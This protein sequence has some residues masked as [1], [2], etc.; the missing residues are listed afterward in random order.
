MSK[1]FIKRISFETEVENNHTRF[2]VSHIVKQCTNME[3][4]VKFHVNK[5]KIQNQ[6]EQI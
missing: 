5:L 3:S 1:F 6:Q 4:A 2:V